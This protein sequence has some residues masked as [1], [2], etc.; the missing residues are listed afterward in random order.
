M[1]TKCREHLEEF[2]PTVKFHLWEMGNSYATL[3]QGMGA[4]CNIEIDVI[5][6]ASIKAS[7]VKIKGR[8]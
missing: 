2:V 7:K 5:R 8:G 3:P 4:H 1:Y 6:S